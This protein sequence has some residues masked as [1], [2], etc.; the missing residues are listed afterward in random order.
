[1]AGP[2]FDSKKTTDHRLA[3]Q[4]VQCVHTSRDKGTRYSL[5]HQNWKMGNCGQTQPAASAPPFGSHGLCPYFYNL[6][7]HH[8]FYAVPKPQQCRS[9]IAPTRIPKNFQMGYM[10]TRKDYVQGEV[11]ALTSK[12][13][14]YNVLPKDFHE[15]NEVDNSYKRR[16]NFTNADSFDIKY[17]NLFSQ[18][19]SSSGD[20]EEVVV[21]NDTED[22]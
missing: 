1:M 18:L 2:G 9:K 17:I 21:L 13:Y 19:G 7:F 3:A 16:W 4:N 8:P 6:A 20:D 14:P 5:C 12:E 10:E 15:D 11:F 22:Y